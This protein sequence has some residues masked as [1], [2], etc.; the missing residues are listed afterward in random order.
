[1]MNRFYTII[2]ILF[3]GLSWA[4]YSYVPFI[5]GTKNSIQHKTIPTI[6]KRDK[7]IISL[8]EMADVCSDISSAQT[9][10]TAPTDVN[11]GVFTVTTISGCMDD[12][13]PEDSLGDCG[14]ATHPTVWFKIETDINASTLFTFVSTPGS[15]QPVWSVYTGNCET[16][17]ILNGG[18]ISDPTPCS[19]GD[20]NPEAHNN[21]IPK[22]PDG[23]PIQTFYIA[24]SAQGIIDNPEFTLSSFTQAGCVTCI[25]NDVC[26]S[27]ATFEIIKR[28]SARPLDDPQFCQGEEVTVCIDFFYDP[29]ETG[30]DW[31]H[32][33]IPDFGKGWDMVVFDPANVTVTPAGSVWLGPDDGD[34]A[35]Y[36]TEQMPLICSYVDDQG[37][38]RLCNIKCGTCPCSPP[39]AQGSPLPNG[40]FWNSNGGAAC[41][42]TCNPATRYGL[43]NSNAGA[44][45]KIC[46]N[47]KTRVFDNNDVCN[48]QKDLRIS[49]VTTSDGVSGCWNDP[50][51]ECKLDV[52]QIGPEWELD[53]SILPEQTATFTNDTM[54]Y[55]G[56]KTNVTILIQDT[57]NVVLVQPL[58]SE[59]ITGMNTYKFQQPGGLISDRLINLSDTVQIAQYLVFS[60]PENGF[61]LSKPDTLAIFVTSSLCGH[62]NGKKQWPTCETASQNSF[63]CNLSDFDLFCG[64]MF[65]ETNQGPS[66]F[67][68]CQNGGISNNMTWFAFVAGHGNY[69]IV[70]RP[71]NCIPGTGGQ[72]GLQ[73]AVYTDCTF[74][75]A[76]FCH[77]ECS[78]GTVSIPGTMLTPGQIY[79]LLLDGCA[80]SYCDFE[81]DLIGSYSNQNLPCDDG[82]PETINDA[83]DENCECKGVKDTCDPL[84]P[85]VQS[86]SCKVASEN[87]VICN[88]SLLN[89]M[90][91][92]MFSNTSTDPAPNPLCPDGG[93][94]NNMTWIAFVAG[95]GSYNIVVTPSNCQP[96]NGGQ[97]G[98]QIG[99]YSDCSFTEA[100]F[101]N[102]PC[103]S[104]PVSIPDSL[105]TPGQ[106][107][108]LFIDGCAG[109]VCE[110]KI[111]VTGTYS[112][113]PVPCDDGNPETTNDVYNEN[114]KCK[115][116]KDTCDPLP[117]FVQSESCKVA[118][119]N[120]VICN[121]SL[122]NQ[123]CG[124]MFSNT[125][126]DPAPN[127]LCPDGGVSNNMTWIAFVAGEGS[128]NIV[129]TPSNCQPGNGGQLGAQIGV[130]SDCSFTEAV[131]CNA[132]CESVPVSIPD[133]LLTPGQTYYLFIDGCAGSVCE[134]K[135]DVTGTYSSEPVPCDDGNPETTNDVYDENCKCKGVKDT[136]DPLPP[137]VQSESCKVASENTVICNLSLLNQMCGEMFSN[138][139]TD[140]A[141][142]PLCP[143]GG[144]SNNMT[145]IAFV[146]GEGSYNIVVTPSNCQP[147]N[148]G[149]LGAQI[150][151][152]S[153]CS[154]TEAVFCNAPCESVPVSIPDSLLTPGQTYY[155]FIDGCA[156]SVCEYKI[157]VTGTYSSEPV[158]C[159]D[160]N[161]ET[162]NDVYDE[163]CECKGELINATNQE[164]RDKMQIFPN[165]ANEN[166][167]VINTGKYKDIDISI[168]N[169]VGETIVIQ[170][171]KVE[172]GYEL[173]TAGLSPGVYLIKIR[174]DNVSSSYK[175]V[176]Y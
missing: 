34:C 166:V 13:T 159:D 30:V 46:M 149:Q 22:G 124:E 142:N 106:T 115:G 94:S 37:I 141:P 12:A 77:P 11:C 38:L 162:I 19:N 145:W 114:C 52:A 172:N 170:K 119:E 51:A 117:P 138:T 4:A 128:Y 107:Y 123:M 164:N 126:T 43:P 86:E 9:L 75:N 125:S 99:V 79:Y 64:E 7:T 133:S 135:I 111:D 80:G 163:N 73:A 57:N 16:L 66:P 29:S 61:C 120:T 10:Q 109:S 130:Y 91:G 55:N 127:P 18:S 153:D 134:Y 62:V 71:S 173:H 132:P 169:A 39:L 148:G 83:Y 101:C 17:T 15:W 156:G 20:N 146:A 47:L 26:S 27:D 144:V 1:M 40:W 103:E 112:S 8:C 108:Y 53:C 129:V 33:L 174:K 100:V 160:G 151:V 154:F 85:F 21:S 122:L 82:N 44:D 96:G 5:T 113:E 67:P 25:G 36:I 157:D 143:D 69:E 140:P 31:F 68:L 97:L 59:F 118:S 167:Y 65:K 104:V 150:G 87:T 41:Q 74:S 23:T 45:V 78:N 6:P 92:E 110:Y 63:F 81:F 165:P 76:V 54:I 176:K 89:Q 161:P 105:L 168:L 137:F 175:L 50:I 35:P 90:C 70:I 139:S 60:L 152:Y 3:S 84:P 58:E 102:A 72:I 98:A 116:V 32:G 2:F 48:D 14:F 28:S 93:V 155:L 121:L 158:P 147:G 88:L 171:S 49:F 131:F 24:V 136:C 42:N 95:E 56:E